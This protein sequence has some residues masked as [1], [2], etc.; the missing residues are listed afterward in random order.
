VYVTCKAGLVGSATLLMVISLG[1]LL[2]ILRLSRQYAE[3]NSS[4]SGHD[5]GTVSADDGDDNVNSAP[6]DAS[7]CSVVNLT[8][9]PVDLLLQHQVFVIT[10][11]LLFRFYWSICESSYV[12]FKWNYF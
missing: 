1:I 6:Q 10:V 11:S 12:P 4:V 9:N 7:T 3:R 5:Y 8:M 2:I